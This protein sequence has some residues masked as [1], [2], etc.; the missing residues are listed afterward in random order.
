M[1]QALRNLDAVAPGPLHSRVA[2]SPVGLQTLPPLRAGRVLALLPL[3]G[4]LGAA[5]LLPGLEPWL[6]ALKACSVVEFLVSRLVSGCE[7][8]GD[9]CGRHGRRHSVRGAARGFW[10]R[11]ASDGA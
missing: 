7:V 11:C 8:Q 5:A 1:P 3:P 10:S 6:L 4:L 2:V 9:A